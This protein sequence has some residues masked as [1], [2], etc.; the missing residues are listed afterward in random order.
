MRAG[1][2]LAPGNK[3]NAKQVGLVPAPPKTFQSLTNLPRPGIP[4]A[5]LPSFNVREAVFMV[6]NAGI[7]S[8]HRVLANLPALGKR[9]GTAIEK[10]LT[11]LVDFILNYATSSLI[12][13]A[14]YHNHFGN[15]SNPISPETP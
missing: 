14:S 11:C 7:P 6:F 5:S 10:I 9:G 1:H 12:F 8:A 13:M 4:S 15:D 2:R 3:E